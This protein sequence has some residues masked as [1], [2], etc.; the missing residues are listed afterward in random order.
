MNKKM[1]ISLMLIGVLTFAIGMGT[2][3]YFTSEAVSED[4]V[5]TAGTLEIEGPGENFAGGMYEVENI[6][7]GWEDQVD[8][9]VKNIGTL[10]FKYRM[11]LD[12]FEGG[13]TSG[14]NPL[15]I[16]VNDGQWM[17]IGDFD[18]VVL[19]D[20]A[21]GGIA[22]GEEDTFTVYFRFPAAAGNE[23]QGASASLDFSFDATQ[24]NNPGWDEAGNL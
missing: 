13:L 23:Y 4:N 9:T 18:S 10:P 21:N 19:N 24:I 17:N 20:G 8:V 3:A 15:Q 6:Y 16:K 7:P 1:L 2:F 14:A 22:P 11:K 5:F 12:A